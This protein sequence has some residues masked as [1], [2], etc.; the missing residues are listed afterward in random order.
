MQQYNTD[1]HR[2]HVPSFRTFKNYPNKRQ[3]LIGMFYTSYT[4]L[5]NK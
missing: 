4:S 3:Q 1:E 2:M 5:V